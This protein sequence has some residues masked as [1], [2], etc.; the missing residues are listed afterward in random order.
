VLFTVMIALAHRISIHRA[1]L[2][3]LRMIV[4]AAALGLFVQRL[5]ER[6]PWPRPMRP[7]FVVAH[8]GYAFTYS[9]A[10]LLADSAIESMLH[11]ALVL[12]T[13]PSFVL[14]F[15]TGVWLYVMIAGVAYTTLATG[16]AALAEANA[17]RAQLAALRA[18]LHPHFLF[19]A[20]HSV[21]QLIPREPR[22]A[23]EAAE[24]LGALL[25]TTVE[26]DRDLVTLAEECAFVERYLA[27]E[28]MRFGDRLRVTIEVDEDARTGMVPVFALQTLVENAVRHGAAPRVEPTDVVVT[29][30]REGSALRL[31][32]R[33]SGAGSDSH[34]QENGTGLSRLRERLV[35]LYG[36]AAQLTS[37]PLSGGGYDAQ[38]VVPFDRV[39]E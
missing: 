21:V 34:G 39:S 10:L 12:A 22:R 38:L 26:E 5:V 23:A 2:L 1:S 35:V 37:G 31:S 27:I 16:R 36:D 6:Y 15:L 19:N 29:G 4:T 18:Q 33:D 30:R 8:L 7:T 20:L 17:A 28:K 11:G 13:G 24:Q 9:T 3:A 25:R 32:V 14:T